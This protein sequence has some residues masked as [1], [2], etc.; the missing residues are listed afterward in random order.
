MVDQRMYTNSTFSLYSQMSTLSFTAGEG[1]L[2]IDGRTTRAGQT[3][4]V[5]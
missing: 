3:S 1:S 4:V 5:A 2:S